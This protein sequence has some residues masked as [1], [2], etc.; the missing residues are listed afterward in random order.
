MQDRS[1]MPTIRLPGNRRGT[2][3]TPGASLMKNLMRQHW[4]RVSPIFFIGTVTTAAGTTIYQDDLTIFIGMIIMGLGVVAMWMAETGK[5]RLVT[6]PGPLIFILGTMLSAM[7]MTITPSGELLCGGMI[8]T[9]IGTI[10]MWLVWVGRLGINSAIVA[11]LFAVGIIIEAIS[12]TVM[13]SDLLIM[14]G[15]IA[16]G[17]GAFGMWAFE[18]ILEK[19]EDGDTAE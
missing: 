10:I 17:I 7:S 11:I 3:R 4:I 8:L 2:I 16:T 15:M 6:I 13:P 12:L 9:G 5:L 14:I 19:D 1:N 18:L